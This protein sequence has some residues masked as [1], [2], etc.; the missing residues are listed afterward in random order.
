M[1]SLLLRPISADLP[2]RLMRFLLTLALALLLCHDATAADKIKNR[3][4]Q[5]G[6]VL[7]TQPNR[8]FAGTETVTTTPLPGAGDP[9]GPFATFPKT[10]NSEQTP[11]Y[12]VFE[13]FLIEG[14][15]YT[16]VAQERLQRKWSKPANL[17]VNGPVKYAVEKQTLFVV[18]EDGKEHEM[19]IVKKILPAK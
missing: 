5:I 16:Y 17:T 8:Y 14:D 15:K 13:T 7:D 9:D 4:W 11:V 3:N 6:K 18:D 10:T 19:E 2:A 12:R 1:L